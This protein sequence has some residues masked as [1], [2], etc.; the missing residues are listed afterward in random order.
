MDRLKFL[1]PDS[2]ACDEPTKRFLLLHF[3][4]Y[5]WVLAKRTA[6]WLVGGKS[7]RVSVCQSVRVRQSAARRESVCRA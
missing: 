7:C 3:P 6:G 1:G 2:S 4:A 5:S